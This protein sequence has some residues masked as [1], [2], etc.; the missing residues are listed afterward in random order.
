MN[1]SLSLEWRSHQ[2][3]AYEH[4]LAAREV[5]T[6]F[7][8]QPTPTTSGFRAVLR[9]HPDRAELERLTYF[10]SVTFGSTE[11]VPLQSKLETSA[12]MG[13]ARQST[14]YSAHGLHEYKG[15]FNPQIVRAIGNVMALRPGA[16]VLDP[17]CGSGTSIL[18]CAHA[19]W[20]AVG[21]DCNPL[22]AFVSKA[23][24]GLLRVPPRALEAEIAKL[25]D[26]LEPF[27]SLDFTVAFSRGAL[28]RLRSAAPSEP[29]ALPNHA[30]LARWFA[31]SVL[32]QLAVIS[33]VIDAVSTEAVRDA[34]LVV[35]SDVL[36][37][38]SWQE[39][40]DLRIRRRKVA[41]PNYPAIPLFL[42][43]LARRIDTVQRAR[44]VVGRVPGQQL[45]LL[46]DARDPKTSARFPRGVAARRFDG[47]I[48]SPPYATA[49]PYID[50]QRLSL[51]F[52]GL[53]DEAEIRRLERT[54]IGNRELGTKERAT[55]EQEIAS[56]ALPEDVRALCHRAQKLSA[57]PEDGF[58]RKN[59]PALLLR[60]F[61]DMQAVFKNVLPWVQPSGFFAMVVGPNRTV[62]G[63]QEIPIDTPSLLAQVAV[64]E[65]WMLRE[66]VPLNAYQRYD[67]HQR[68][69][70]REEAL[71]VLTRKRGPK[72]T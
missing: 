70:I 47:V 46:A 28:A 58:R 33:S 67:L 30:Y 57:S 15:K 44:A 32:S 54:L 2:Y 29:A 35:L 68:N 43:A 31:P 34:C 53:A 20:N 21:I 24:V 8:V 25:R 51:A 12:G 9:K 42:T 6:L 41:E 60:Y 48:T 50:T 36:R 5:A 71:V 1:L 66:I 40:A 65:G 14:R 64:A 72:G 13:R 56:S 62:L 18:E 55:L 16:W 26:R 3:F 19:G 61:R 52:L 49:L 59:V 23:K 27:G 10:A 17:F 11:I 22:A 37:D 4:Q 7:G 45:A 63:G 69:A 39:P 38:V